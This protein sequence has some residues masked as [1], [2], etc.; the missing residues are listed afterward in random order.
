LPELLAFIGFL[1]VC[2]LL[3]GLPAVVMEH[4]RVKREG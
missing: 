1:F 4:Q 3:F 2:W